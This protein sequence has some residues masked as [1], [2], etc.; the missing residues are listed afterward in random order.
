MDVLGDQR[1]GLSMRWSSSFLDQGPGQPPIQALSHCHRAGCSTAGDWCRSLESGYHVLLTAAQSARWPGKANRTAAP[2]PPRR[3]IRSA[4]QQQTNHQVRSGSKSVVVGVAS[5]AWGG[6]GVMARSGT[7]CVETLQLYSDMP[8]FAAVILLDFGVVH[9]CACIQAIHR[10]KLKLRITNTARTRSR[11]FGPRGGATAHHTKEKHSELGGK[12]VRAR[13]Y[14]CTVIW[15]LFWPFLKICSRSGF[16]QFK[17]QPG[18]HY[19]IVIEY[20]FRR[21]FQ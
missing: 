13:K 9:G 10:M 12:I 15:G 7:F 18:Y 14:F 11:Q 4:S 2:S 21:G 1:A 6:G 5:T 20:I 16:A 3:V 19:A 17:N 8:V